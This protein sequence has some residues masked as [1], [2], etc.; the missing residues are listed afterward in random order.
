MLKKAYLEITNVCNLSCSFCHGTSRKPHFL[1]LE[2]FE[3]LTERLRGRVEFLYFHLMGEPLLHPELSRFFRIAEEKGF[4]VILTT[5]GTLLRKRMEELLTAR[6]LYKVSISL[7]CYEV[8]AMGRSLEGYLGDCFAFC[9]AAS[10]QG[11]LSVLRLWN[12][13]GE[14]QLNQQ[15]L[16]QMEAF[17]PKPWRDTYS[18][19][20]LA[21]RTFLEWGERFDWPD[22]SAPM[23]EGS[24]GCY[25]LRDQ[26]GIHCDGTVVPCCLDAEG[27]IPLG[28]LFTQELPEI[29][30]SKR[31][32]EL[33]KSLQNRKPCEALCKH[34]GYA[35]IKKY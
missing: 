31:A 23:Q 5:N 27:G 12:Q 10:Q 16:S 8:N 18:G 6:S 32:V 1:S 4:K 7:H 20:R 28:N 21:D 22:P 34:C 14:D 33:R 35:A 17:F 19:S 15:I 11:K 13:G 26:I 9:K 24:Y 25:G 29:L 30:G 2:E 3:I